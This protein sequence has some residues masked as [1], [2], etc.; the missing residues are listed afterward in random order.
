MSNKRKHSDDNKV[1]ELVSTNSL[2]RNLFTVIGNTIEE[3]EGEN[4]DAHILRSKPKEA[5]EEKTTG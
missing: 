1:V 5:K 2:D 3:G 4:L